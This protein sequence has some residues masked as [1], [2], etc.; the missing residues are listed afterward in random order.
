ML[1]P[2]AIFALLTLTV[3][4]VIGAYRIWRLLEMIK[5][6]ERLSRQS[7][8]QYRSLFEDSPLSIVVCREGQVEYANRSALAVFAAE[9][10]EQLVHRPLV[11]RL[12]PRYR[13]SVIEQFQSLSEAHPSGPLTEMQVLR[14]DGQLVDVEV[15]IALFI[16]G[17]NLAQYVVFWD[18][19]ERKRREEMLRER[20]AELAHVMRLHTMG[21]IAAEM[22][23]E[24]NQPL[25]AI[26]NFAEAGLM[27]LRSGTPD[28]VAQ[29]QGCLEHIY[30]QAAR[31]AQI[32][33]NLRNFVSKTEGV[34]QEVSFNGLVRDALELV[35]VEARRKRAEV[36]LALD[37]RDVSVHVNPVQ[38]QQVLV[39]L[40]INAF[41]AMETLPQERRH[42]RVTTCIEASQVQ[43]TVEDSGPGVSEDDLSR[44]F[45]PFYTTKSQGMGMGLAVS[46]TIVISHGGK[47][48]AERNERGGT[49]FRMTLPRDT[50]P[51]ANVSSA[52]ADMTNV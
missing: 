18:V 35:V 48:W 29:L 7:E 9:Q 2:L 43:L 39:N 14:T 1:I 34:F 17:G 15:L 42:V 24:I 30:T 3:V 47:I 16:Y 21:E 40:L 38:I 52:S 32:V 45:E 46:R 6:A 41:E 4:A 13:V 49:T 37:R 28:R 22:A 50:M 33:K 27:H 31:A 10:L 5:A 23:H 19:S 8:Q 51:V 26:S 20:E 12:H 44:V 11:E 25:Y 36:E